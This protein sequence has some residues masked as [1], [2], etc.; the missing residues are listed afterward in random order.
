MTVLNSW[1]L[2]MA[3]ADRQRNL[4]RE[5]RDLR[6]VEEATRGRARGGRPGLHLPRSVAMCFG[7]TCLRLEIVASGAAS[8]RTG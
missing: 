2:E 8:G 7:S 4:T 1:D 3:E 5:L 6:L